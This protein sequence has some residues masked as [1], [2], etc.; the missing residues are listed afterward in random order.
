MR[1]CWSDL[2]FQMRRLTT[3]QLNISREVMKKMQAK[4]LPELVKMAGT[5]VPIPV[6]SRQSASNRQSKVAV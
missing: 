1:I 2:K 4:S 5:Y 3:W 6:E